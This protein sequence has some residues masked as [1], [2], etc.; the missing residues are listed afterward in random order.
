MATITLK[1]ELDGIE[2]DDLDGMEQKVYAAL[3]K[4][5]GANLVSV[6]EDEREDEED[7]D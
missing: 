5:Q 4:L 7:E 6:V 1:V 3:E 2:N